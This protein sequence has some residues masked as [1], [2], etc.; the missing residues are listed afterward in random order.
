MEESRTPSPTSEKSNSEIKSS[1]SFQELMQII[2]N[3]RTKESTIISTDGFE[4]M[5]D[6]TSF[7][8]DI[9]TK[10]FIDPSKLPD[11]QRDDM[12]FYV[13]KTHNPKNKSFTFRPEIEVYRRDSKSLPALED[14]TIDWEETVYM[15]IISHQLVYTA[16][17]AVC[18]RT[19]EHHL[20]ILR[21]FSQRVYPSPS[22]RRMDDK[23]TEEEL[24]Y[25]NIYFTVDNFEEAFGD[26][27]VRD[28]ELVSVELTASDRHGRAQGVIF[29]GAVRYEVLKKV[30]DARLS[31]T[32]KMMQTMS[33]GMIKQNKRVEFV[34]MRGPKSKGHAEIAVS[35]VPGSGPETPNK[36]NFKL[37][38]F[39]DEQAQDPNQQN[40][41]THRRM[42]DP[43]E[44]FSSLVRGGIRRLSMK[45]SR[46]E[47]E[48]VNAGIVNCQEVE[49]TTLQSELEQSTHANG[50]LGKAFGQAWMLFKE[51]KRATSVALNS[52]LTYITLPWH[53]IIADLMD[54]QQKPVLT[55]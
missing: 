31:L 30:Y 34:R 40:Q 16:T 53:W 1:D 10:Y 20:Q 41:Y 5:N 46:S 50:F 49:A 27:V 37:E 3:E 4:V 36:E 28:G 13:R 24:T 29:L 38:D 45:K 7:W 22:K 9:F 26:I 14:K 44:S 25:P 54:A 23:G 15:N 19:S 11:D 47:T 8:T 32:S 21:K 2:K 17:C 6:S 43:S 35:R 39:N 33:L 42:S 52:Y 48:D 12:L 18:T 51:Q 55:S